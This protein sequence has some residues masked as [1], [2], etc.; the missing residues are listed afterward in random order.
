M[1]TLLT[2]RR[3][4]GP[5]AVL[6]VMPFEDEPKLV[7]HYMQ[8]N[9]DVIA[10]GLVF[11]SVAESKVE[12]TIRFPFVPKQKAGFNM[13]KIDQ[14][15]WQTARLFPMFQQPGPRTH[16]QLEGGPPNYHD[17]G[18]LY[19][20][21]HLGR[22]IALYHNSSLS[23][24]LDQVRVNVQRF[25]YPPYENDKFLFALQ[26]FFPLIL[27]LSFIYPSVNLTKNIVLEK[28]QRLKEAMKMMGLQDWLHWTSWFV[29][30]FFWSLISVAIITCLL[31]MHLKPNLAIISKSDPMLVL[32]FF[33]LYTISSICFCFLVS[34]FFSKVGPALVPWPSW[35]S[36]TVNLL[37][38]QANIA[39]V[40]AGALY[41]AT[42]LPYFQVNINYQ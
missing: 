14:F 6:A 35:S 9:S 17:E 31:C 27:M 40:I 5:N 15:T 42:F 16:H 32:L 33:V 8:E 19:V 29:N 41:F 30:S 13:Q 4:N 24:R 7:S 38:S 22:S 25:P 11:H 12:V 28:E 1:L 21:H 39:G 2:E 20:H 37:F 34:T 23:G 36:L 10:C 18:F 3:V 26:F